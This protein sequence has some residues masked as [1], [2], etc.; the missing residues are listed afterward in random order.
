MREKIRSTAAD[1][2]ISWG[3]INNFLHIRPIEVIVR[4]TSQR[5]EPRFR[6][7]IWTEIREVVDVETGVDVVDGVV[8]V[9]VEITAWS[10]VVR[11]CRNLSGG[12]K[13]V[14]VLVEEVGETARVSTRGYVGHVRFVEA[15]YILV[16][17]E[18]GDDRS[19]CCQ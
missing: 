7:N 12:W 14:G 8:D 15:D 6:P 1:E 17:L 13:L 2:I 3:R 11:C 4:S 9:V 18:S 19:Y 10:V 16:V 5:R